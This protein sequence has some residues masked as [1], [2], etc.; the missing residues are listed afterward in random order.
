LTYLYDREVAKRNE[1]LLGLVD[2]VNS[3]G[4]YFQAILRQSL[5]IRDD[6]N[7]FSFFGFSKDKS[8]TLGYLESHDEIVEDLLKL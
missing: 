8:K 7:T 4:S 2:S 5:T 3:F 1:Y 6:D